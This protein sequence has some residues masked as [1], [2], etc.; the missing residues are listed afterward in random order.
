MLV[1]PGKPKL[2]QIQ[3]PTSS[4]NSRKEIFSP[5]QHSNVSQ[6]ST[7]V[8]NQPEVSLFSPYD[9]PVTGTPFSDVSTVTSPI[10]PTPQN[11]PN[12]SLQT[13]LSMF[14]KQPVTPRRRISPQSDV[15]M[16][17]TDQRRMKSLADPF[18]SPLSHRSSYISCGSSYI[19][20]SPPEL[21][22]SSTLDNRSLCDYSIMNQVALQE[23][24]L[25]SMNK[26]I[27]STAKA[28]DAI[29][30]H[31]FGLTHPELSSFRSDSLRS[32]IDNILLSSLQKVFPQASSSSLS[33]LA[34]WLLVDQHF[35]Q[36]FATAPPDFLH[37]ASGSSY[38]LSPD[39][40][41]IMSV[42]ARPSP[43]V[44]RGPWV[45][46]VD[47]PASSW[48]PP[49]KR[50]IS[51]PIN[52]SGIP[53]KAKS[54]LGISS[55]LTGCTSQPYTH[56][57]TDRTDTNTKRVRLEE[58]ARYVHSSVQIVGQKLIKDIMAAASTP[59]MANYHVGSKSSRRS[60]HMR[61][62]SIAV[63]TNNPI[64]AMDEIAVKALW[65]ACR[66]LASMV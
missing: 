17:S 45:D 12:L 26:A 4:S 18:R 56:E 64:G 14:Q 46:L 40:Q 13:N 15:T 50:S 27:S 63:G 48:S 23:K 2:V 20:E 29:A 65:E 47:L 62:R 57:F 5:S 44:S 24:Y 37:G 31:N 32:S 35:T 52:T 34:A 55:G 58:K 33:T 11:H 59:S 53:S 25:H 30:I 22:R 54:I 38:T 10:T 3:R 41:V 42:S 51:T 61:D 7:P 36:L 60:K 28:L 19:D 49:R 39:E 43:V 66:C 16:F 1:G 8:C 9:T 6:P 21:T